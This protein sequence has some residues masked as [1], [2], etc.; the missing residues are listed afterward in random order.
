MNNPIFILLVIVAI[1][2]LAVFI[3][4][5]I[6]D[7]SKTLELIFTFLLSLAFSIAS[8]CVG[9]SDK[10]SETSTSD[11]SA[12]ISYTASN[13]HNETSNETTEESTI[14]GNSFSKKLSYEDENYTVKFITPT[15]G[16]YRFD[17]EINDVNCDYKV[18]LMDSKKEIIFDS[19]YSVYGNGNTCILIKNEKYTLTVEQLEGFPIATIKIGVPSE[20]AMLQ[21]EN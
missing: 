12:S 17:Y 18:V 14:N 13:S 19:E 16:T 20:S 3:A 10:T 15:D 11:Y 7:P 1:I 6:K 5:I 9:V 2:A 8:F 21:F 4:I